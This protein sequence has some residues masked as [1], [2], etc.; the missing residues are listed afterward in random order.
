ME[1]IAVH[2]IAAPTEDAA[3]LVRELEDELSALYLPEQRHGFSLDALFQPH[4]R[5]FI[6]FVDGKAA[7]CG[8]VAF[9]D[10]FAE[11]KR[12]YVRQAWRGQG[13]ADAVMAR[14]AEEA[15]KA[16]F[17][18]LRLETGSHSHPAIAFYRRSGFVDCPMFEPYAS[19]PPHTVET[20]LFLEMRL[21]PE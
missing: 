6:A 15:G 11:I 13:V 16:G 17:S 18:V 21:S 9:F 3:A 19:L 10:G 14:L 2:L 7:G 12:M 8:G 5:F 4:I 1:K 20:S